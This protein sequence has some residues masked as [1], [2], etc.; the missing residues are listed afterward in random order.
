MNSNIGGDQRLGLFAR[1]LR[2][3][4]TFSAM[5]LVC[6]LLA[7][8]SAEYY[9]K[10]AD[11]EVYRIVAV[12]QKR[13]LG[14]DKGFTIEPSTGDPL[15]GL[16]RRFQPLVQENAAAPV[17]KPAAAA[18]PP[19]VISLDK[20]VEIAIRNSNDYQTNKE[21]V[22]LSALSLTLERSRWTPQFSEL[23]TGQYNRADRD[24]YYTGSSQFGVSELLATGGMLTADLT[25]NLLRYT[26]GDPRASAISLLTANFTQPL[27]RGAGQ[28]VAQ[29]SLTQAER[30]VIYS[31]RSFARYHRTFAVSVATNYYRLLEQRSVVQN[32]YANYVSSVRSRQQSEKLAEASKMPPAQVDQTRQAE[33]QAKDS[34]LSA[35][36]SYHSSLDQFKIQLGLRADA[37]VDVDTDELTKL[38]SVGIIAPKLT[39][40]NAVKQALAL[41]LDLLNQRDATAD[42]AR[43]VNVAANGLGPDVSLVAAASVP[44]SSVEN[45]PTT[46]RFEQATYSAGFNV[47]LPL[48]RTA[49]RN[50]YRQALISLDQARRSLILL[51]DN[52]KSQV[53][54]EW[55]TLQER[56]ESYEIQRAGVALAEHRVTGTV[57]LLDAGRATARDL[58]DAQ[59]SLLSAQNALIA[60][61]VDH[62]VA[63]LQLWRDVE[64]LLVTPEGSLEEHA[65]A[66]HAAT[67]PPAR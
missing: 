14:A 20:A 10:S 7:G 67:D 58:L 64:T 55:R 61:L 41:R 34:W 42:A 6:A 13:A 54:D 40:E 50:T 44:S 33:L 43:Q 36:E 47:S 21:G 66:G 52:I 49:E 1:N 46:L 39:A 62:T 56:K 11:K 63:R 45:R 57:L 5:A 53:R 32:Q 15:E 29:E 12:K 2:Q 3:A 4:L 65:D 35:E 16:P 38:V 26:T 59:A 37:N 51:E 25:T 60:A 8:C 23:L 22:Y 28:A 31:V 27:W 17:P 48:Y 9:R 19:A 18:N 24:E 30:N